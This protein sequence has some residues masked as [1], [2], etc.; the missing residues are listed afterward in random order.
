MISNCNYRYLVSNRLCLSHKYMRP[1]IAHDMTNQSNQI[2]LCQTW[3][4]YIYQ[5]RILITIKWSETYI[6]REQYSIPTECTVYCIE[7]IIVLNIVLNVLL[8]WILYWIYDCMHCVLY[9]LEGQGPFV[10][11]NKLLLLLLL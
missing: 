2:S 8:H 6:M 4:T 10:F 3:N 5:F 9:W 7:C 1:M 11:W